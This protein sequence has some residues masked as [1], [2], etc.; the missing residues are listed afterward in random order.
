MS[1]TEDKVIWRPDLHALLGKSS[2]TIR[3]WI[4]SGKLPKPDV[5]ITRKTHGWRVST[6]RAAGVNIA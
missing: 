6:L 5:Q 2:E 1:E 3:R 4:Q